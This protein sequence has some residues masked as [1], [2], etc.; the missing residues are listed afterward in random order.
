MI[1]LV[2]YG[3]LVVYGNQY[4]VEIA[5]IVFLSLPQSRL[6]SNARFLTKWNWLAISLGNSVYFQFCCVLIASL[7]LSGNS[8]MYYTV[9]WLLTVCVSWTVW[10]VD[11]VMIIYW[12]FNTDGLQCYVYI[13]P[14]QD[15]DISGQQ[16][17]PMDCAVR[18]QN[19][20]PRFSQP[21]W[22]C[23]TQWRTSMK[24]LEVKFNWWISL[25][26]E[27]LVKSGKVSNI[28]GWCCSAMLKYDYRPVTL[29]TR[30]LID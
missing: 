9:N 10:W 15:A 16:G 14:N 2:P 5:H 12:V 8:P 19:R 30:I 23:P 11:I 21:D 28:C 17:R 18:W 22:S 27:I 6:V 4:V 1:L 26:L 3:A 7:G 24:F 25:V 29:L 20:V 13:E